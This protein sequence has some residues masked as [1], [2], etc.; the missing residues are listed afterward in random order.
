MRAFLRGDGSSTL[1]D[2]LTRLR[3]SPLPESPCGGNGTCGKCRARFVTGAPAPTAEDSRLIAKE[4]LARGVRLSCKAVPSGECSVELDSSPARGAYRVVAGYSLPGSKSILPSGAS[5]ASALSGTSSADGPLA[6][7]VDLGTTTIA[8]ELLDP[9]SRATLASGSLLNGQRRFGADVLSR[10]K[11]ATEGFAGELR[12]QARLDILAGIAHLLADAGV[13]GSRVERVTVAGNTVMDHL[14]LGL[15]AVGLAASPFTPEATRFPPAR[16][17]DVFGSAS[18]GGEIADGVKLIS[19]DCPVFIV[20]CVGAF[21]GGDIVA[22]IAALGLRSESES[23]AELFID[24]GTNAEMAL[25]WNGTIRCASAAAGPAF[26]GGSI[27]SGVGSVSGAVSAVTLDGNKF[28][29]DLVGGDLARKPV[30]LCGTGLIDFVACALELGLITSDGALS[31]VCAETGI[32]LDPAGTVRLT[33]PDVRSL[34]LAKAA[35]RASIEILLDSAGLAASDVSRVYLAGGFGL[36]LREESAL[37]IGLLPP[38]FRGKTIPVG[39]SSL[40]GA[41]AFALDAAMGARFDEVLA[42]CEQVSLAEHPRF[43][44]VFMDSME[45]GS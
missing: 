8:L 31:P 45:F 24:L 18:G 44:A 30:G 4:D 43:A 7:A 23:G 21:I 14:F 9:G 12:D 37:A 1:L 16:F 33:A 28:A 3:V 5:G 26:E 15:S 27:S 6:I 25:A 13:S 35:V 20:P 32:F 11:A 34:Q 39:N 40:A 19:P 42:R 36:Y 41:S 2:L 10:V 29:W 38:A 22:G 17:A